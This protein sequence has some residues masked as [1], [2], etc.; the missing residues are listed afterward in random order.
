MMMT[1]AK[2][3][4]GGRHGAIVSCKDGAVALTDRLRAAVFARDKGICSFSGLSVWM[5]DY[6]A[7]PFAQPDWVD[8]IRPKSRGGRDTL[9]NLVCASFF[10]NRKKLNN[11]ADCDY[12]FRDGRPT[13]TYFFTHGE[14]STEQGRLLARHSCLTE[15]DWYFNRAVYNIMVAL[16]DD[17]AEVD[18]RRKH[19]YWLGSAYKRLT[20]WR[21]YSGE[22]DGRAF[23]RRGLVRFPDSPD[24]QLMLALASADEPELV[25]IY[26]QMEV[27]YRANATALAAFAQAQTDR[28]RLAVIRRA[29]KNRNVTPPLLNVLR[30][31]ASRI[32]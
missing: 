13:E 18:V 11:G 10:Y 24:I 8:H 26:K 17:F 23:V 12:L 5:M 4:S 7:V 21:K 1:L 30:R 2:P 19:N 3:I 16:A 6:G 29:E 15:S 31:N 27:H 25:K 22:T 32:K 14:L 28:Q 20:A 9:D